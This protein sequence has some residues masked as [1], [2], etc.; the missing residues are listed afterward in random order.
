M[1]LLS[2]I[3]HE[4]EN[5]YNEEL[6]TRRFL[7]QKIV[8]YFTILLINMA[9]LAV[10]SK[11]LFDN[12]QNI[13]VLVKSLNIIVISIFI[14]AFFLMILQCFFFYKSFFRLKKDYLEMPVHEIRKRHLL[15]GK[16]K[17]LN[18]TYWSYFE[19]NIS[20]EA[21]YAY[22]KDSYIYCAVKNRETNVKRQNALIYFENLLYST[23]IMRFINYYILYMKGSITTWILN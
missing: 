17:V 21:L 20:E 9:L 12:R 13:T 11:Y 23:F 22:M 16:S 2:D 4:Y 19:L 7:D 6:Q 18:G 5:I 1:I 10:Q 15:I 3:V 8:T 14:F